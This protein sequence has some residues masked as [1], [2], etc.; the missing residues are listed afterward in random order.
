MWYGSLVLVITSAHVVNLSGAQ[1][2]GGGTGAISSTSSSGLRYDSAGSATATSIVLG[3]SV[4][5]AID[6]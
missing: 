3:L 4:L 6:E 1:F 5:E 2:R